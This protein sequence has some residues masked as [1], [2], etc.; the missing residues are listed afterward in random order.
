MKKYFVIEVSDEPCALDRDL[1]SAL[2]FT[3]QD[4]DNKGTRGLGR[5]ISHIKKACREG[6]ASLMAFCCLFR[7]GVRNHCSCGSMSSKGRTLYSPPE[8]FNA[9]K[10][11]GD[12]VGQALRLLSTDIS[13]ATGSLCL[14]PGSF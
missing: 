7:Q 8:N 3:R 5:I 9:M 4:L 13:T 10:R 6:L 12:W 1:K 14:G 2:L 11:A